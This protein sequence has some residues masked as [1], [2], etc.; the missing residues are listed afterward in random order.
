MLMRIA[1]RSE[2]L[3][4]GD[5]FDC[6]PFL[7]FDPAAVPV[8]QKPPG[9]K[10]NTDSQLGLDSERDI[11]DM[12]ADDW[13]VF[14]EQKHALLVRAKGGMAMVLSQDCDADRKDTLVVCQ[15]NTCAQEKVRY[16]EKTFVKNHKTIMER[17]DYLLLRPQKDLLDE[18]SVVCFG[19]IQVFPIETL[20]KLRDVQ[21]TRR[22]MPEAC[23]YLREKLSDYLGRYA[24]DDALLFS[25]EEM[26]TGD[27]LKRKLKER[28]P[29]RDDPLRARISDSLYLFL[30]REGYDDVT[31]DYAAIGK[32]FPFSSGLPDVLA[33]KGGKQ[34]LFLVEGSRVSSLKDSAYRLRAFTDFV[35]RTAGTRLYLVADVEYSPFR[36][37]LP[38]K[39]HIPVTCP[40]SMY[41]WL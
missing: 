35:R 3:R 32:T 26:G 18:A 20:W 41:Q 36:W 30:K 29:A 14:S 1:D 12:S 28:D 4:Q 33:R 39:G 27:F 11:R 15:V 38:Y 40:Q 31:N 10:D 8:V 2:P 6:L 21:R 19:K 16:D 24:L 37:W 25:E 7:L 9:K 22:L 13:Q 17:K 5:I 34:H 23:E